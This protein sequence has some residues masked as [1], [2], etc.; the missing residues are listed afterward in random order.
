MKAGDW[1][2][3]FLASPDRYLSRVKARRIDIE[4]DAM[5]ARQQ[6]L[7]RF[8]GCSPVMVANDIKDH[9]RMLML[10]IAMIGWIPK[11][12]PSPAIQMKPRDPVSDEARWAKANALAEIL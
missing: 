10:E 1:L 9:H 4:A 6:I 11:P 7:D 12:P 8:P 5:E 3:D 2:M